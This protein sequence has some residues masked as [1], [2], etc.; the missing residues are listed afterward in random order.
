MAIVLLVAGPVCTPALIALDRGNSTGL[1][2]FPLLWFSVSILKQNRWQSVFALVLVS[3]IKPQFALLIFV[4]ISLGWAMQVFVSA[5]SVALTQ[6][7][8]YGFWPDAWPQSIMKSVTMVSGYQSYTYAADPYPPQLSFSSGFATIE[9]GLR[10]LFGSISID[11]LSM[12]PTGLLAVRWQSTVGVV[13]SLVVLLTIA[14]A[15]SRLPLDLRLIVAIAVC[16]Y[17]T[18]TVF[19]YYGV[20]SIVIAALIIRPTY[21]G[22]PYIEMEKTPDGPVVKQMPTA[23]VVV[24]GMIVLATAISL[25]TLPLPLL[26]PPEFA[27]S[28]EGIVF[29][30]SYLSTIGWIVVVIA[31]LG[32]GVLGKLKGQ[33]LFYPGSM[34]QDA[35]C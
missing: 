33:R 31:C 10:S 26:I 4:I 29:T 7:L 16:S 34:I 9:L 19:A 5:V 28:L 23:R 21:F 12:D 27:N 14:I 13:I 30:T 15:R 35:G 3:T 32:L 2:V 22:E 17:A 24:R 1:I 20:T 18:G 25:S 8:A 11:S 6:A